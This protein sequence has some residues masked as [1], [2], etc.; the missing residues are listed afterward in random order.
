MLMMMMSAANASTS[1]TTKVVSHDCFLARW[2]MD[3]MVMASDE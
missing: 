1:Q 2:L 3:W